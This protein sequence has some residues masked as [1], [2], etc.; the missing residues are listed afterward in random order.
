MESAAE[1]KVPNRFLSTMYNHRG[2]VTVAAMALFFRLFLEMGKVTGVE[3]E[4]GKFVNTGYVKVNY[5]L[6][7]TIHTSLKGTAEFV[8]S[9][10]TQPIPGNNSNY[11]Y[12]TDKIGAIIQ[13]G[14]KALHS[15][16]A[17]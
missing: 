1:K 5:P 10:G 9:L 8:G 7:G 6:I 3:W 16:A 12:I 11:I 2:K 14:M 4:Q 17:S 15:S 13:A